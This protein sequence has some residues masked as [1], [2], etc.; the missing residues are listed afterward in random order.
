MIIKNF[1]ASDDGQRGFF[2][3]SGHY[4]IPEA[5]HVSEDICLSF[6]VSF[7][8]DFHIRILPG[9]WTVLL[10]DEL[11]M[12]QIIETVLRIPIRDPVPF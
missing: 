1:S 9:Q 5:S 11:F 4:R 8:F 12:V 2:S 10:C 3:S 7:L 6:S